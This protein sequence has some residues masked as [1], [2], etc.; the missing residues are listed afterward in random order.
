M[1]NARGWEL[2]PL[3]DSPGLRRVFFTDTFQH[4]KIS[5]SGSIAIRAPASRSNAAI[6]HNHV[7]SRLCPLERHLMVN[8]CFNASKCEFC[9]PFYLS[10]SRRWE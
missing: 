5:A 10:T 8:S 7:S 2:S 9:P 3:L 4:P 6:I 1:R